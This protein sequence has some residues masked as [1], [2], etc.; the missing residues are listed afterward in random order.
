M[1]I[2]ALL[3]SLLAVGIPLAGLMIIVS[4]QTLAVML[5]LMLPPIMALLS[6]V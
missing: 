5:P 2:V 6:L 1:D 3:G 4:L